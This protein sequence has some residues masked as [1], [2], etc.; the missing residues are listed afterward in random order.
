MIGFDTHATRRHLPHLQRQG[1]TYFVTVGTI[2]YEILPPAARTIALETCTRDHE[3]TCWIH[4]MVV[5]PE[6]MHLIL[7]PYDEWSLSDVMQRM[8]GVSAHLINRAIGR[9]GSLW[10][11]ESFDHIL[12]S[13]E[14]LTKK[15]EYVAQNPVRRGLVER[16]EDYV[17]LW[18]R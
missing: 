13:D 10:L 14:S 2:N 17:W 16:P 18:P 6:H 12:R 7:T 8:K 15:M 5:M 1:K 11:N 3:V 9:R 4:K